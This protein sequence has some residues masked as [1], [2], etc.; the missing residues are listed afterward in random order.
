MKTRNIFLLALTA[1]LGVSCHSW[2]EPSADAGMES[3]GNKYIQA[4]N[5][6]TIAEVKS[7]FQSEINNNGLKE[8]TQSM[9]IQGIIVG[10]D[11]GSNLYKQLYIQDATGALCLSIDQSGLY[12]CAGVGQCIMVELQG[13]YIGG[14]NKQG[15]VGV[16][17]TK[18]NQEG[19]TPQIGRMSRYV[20]QEHFKLIPSIDGLSTK[21]LSLR[22]MESLDLTTDCGKLVKL[23][24]IKIDGADGEKTFAPS[25]EADKGGGVSRNIE[26]MSNVVIRTSTYAKFAAMVMPT[27]K[28]NITGISSRY[29]D[30][31]Q[32]MIRTTDD[33]EKTTGDEKTDDDVPEVDPA[34]AG[35]A[36]D[37]YN[38]AAALAQAATLPEISKATD[39]NPDNSMVDVVVKGYVKSPSIDTSYG[40]ATYFICDDEKGMGKSLEIYR[41]Y[42]LNGEKFTKSDEIKAGDLVVVQGTIV[43]FKGTLEFT[44]GSK[45]LSING[46]GENPGGDTPT[47]TGDILNVS[48]ESGQGDFTIDDKDL[49]S[50]SYVW[51]ADTSK[52]YMKASAYANNANNA[53]ESWLI[54][55]A[56]SLKNATNPVMTFNNACN[57]VKE[58][59][60]T[61]HIK[62]MV[63]DGTNWAEATI[64][65]MPDGA[66]WT[67]VDSTVDLKAYA[68]KE[69]VKIAFKYVSTTAVAPTWEIKTVT[70]K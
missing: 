8:V 30:T 45:I 47:P 32:I 46:E 33:I 62:V 41:G 37:P 39:A 50:L 58:G 49:G 43:N 4:T 22:N 69:N 7:L 55:P 29:K 65:S 38:V 51:K 1:I 66:S 16:S 13:L 60:I 64:A 35:T 10:D 19:A 70:I 28:I 48:F 11:A 20:W 54:S 14:Y 9:Q 2:D 3:F 6:K 17:Y 63:Y 31:W 42:S 26:G 52:G 25:S 23:V 57:F 68:G 67:F 40:N 12:T 61:D 24:G 21:P 56:F 27:E 36:A 59:T 18:P 5:V 15:Q 44:T 53:A 34:G